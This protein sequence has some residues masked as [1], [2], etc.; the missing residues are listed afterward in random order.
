MSILKSSA[1]A[2]VLIGLVGCGGSDTDTPAPDPAPA[3]PVTESSPGNGEPVAP[4]SAPAVEHS[5]SSEPQTFPPQVEPAHQGRIEDAWQ[6][7]LAG[8]DPTNACAVLKSQL[9]VRGTAPGE[10][11]LAACNIDVPVRYFQTQLARVQSGEASCE[12]VSMLMQ[13]QLPALTMS[14]QRVRE[15]VESD[16]ASG[17]VSG[18]TAV[19]PANEASRIVK[20]RLYDLVVAICPGEAAQM[21]Q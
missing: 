10:R 8:G 5:A 2:L 7:A 14:L 15:M 12:Q 19:D 11:A 16:G 4:T 9:I 1:L 17:D 18:G 6:R 3:E 20:D 21:M 13:S